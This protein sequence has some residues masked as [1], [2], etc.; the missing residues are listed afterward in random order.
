MRSSTA[1]VKSKPA[2]LVRRV[3]PL[4]LDFWGRAWLLTAWCDLSNDFRQFRVDLATRIEHDG[5]AFLPEPGK[6]A[7]DYL[8]RFAT[9]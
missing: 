1:F 2:E 8:A 5:G 4:H 6:T 3:R 9:A 7:E